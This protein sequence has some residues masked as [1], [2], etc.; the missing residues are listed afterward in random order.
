MKKST[1]I[2]AALLALSAGLASAQD[3]LTLQL[4]WVTQAQF[5]GYYVADHPDLPIVADIPGGLAPFQGL[6]SPVHVLNLS[7]LSRQ[8]HVIHP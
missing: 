3:K 7:A 4:K 5:A 1:L 6:S 2:A 8:H